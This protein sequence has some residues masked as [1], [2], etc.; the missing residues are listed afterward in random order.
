VTVYSISPETLG[1][2]A[3]PLELGTHS[4]RGTYALV[5]RVPETAIE[6]GALGTCQFTPGGY[7]Y[8]GSAFGSHGLRRLLRHRRVADGNHDTRHWHVDYLGGDP[9][10]ELV[11]VVCVTDADVECSVASALD[12]ATPSGFGASDCDCESHLAGYDSV[13]KATSLTVSTLRSRM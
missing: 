5:F 8:V 13:E 4:P 3:D 11:R 9:A 2:D 6:V 12:S 7:I 10:V 1:T